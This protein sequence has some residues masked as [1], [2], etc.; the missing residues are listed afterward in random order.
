MSTIFRGIGQNR[1]L[2]CLAS[3]NPLETDVQELA[4]AIANN[5][6]PDALHINM[7]EFAL[8]TNYIKLIR[9]FTLNR[10]IKVLS[11]VG[12]AAPDQL[13]ES[14]CSALS[15]FLSGNSTIRYLDLS[16][17]SSKLEEG[18]LGRGFSRA[19]RGIAQNRTLKHLR[20]RNQNLNINIGDL[21]NALSENNTLVTLDV[22]ENELSLSNF[23]YLANSLRHNTTILELLVFSDKESPMMMLEKSM[24]SVAHLAGLSVPVGRESNLFKASPR[25]EKDRM[26]ETAK[27]L[28]NQ[29]GDE[30][31]MKSTQLAE[32]LARNRF[33]EE[34]R[35]Q[36]ELEDSLYEEMEDYSD[37]SSFSDEF[38]G[39][40]A[41][42]KEVKGARKL[43]MTPEQ[44]SLQTST[45][46]ITRPGVI[47]LQR[48]MTAPHHVTRLEIL[49]SPTEEGTRSPS[50]GLPSPPELV[51]EESPT[52]VITDKEIQ[53]AEYNPETPADNTPHFDQNLVKL[54]RT[55]SEWPLDYERRE[56]T[57]ASY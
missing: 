21:A 56:G 41:V 5:Y 2:S 39:L 18:R 37:S 51:N 15:N 26:P 28:M 34:K 57:R 32:I 8:E 27:T 45:S 22:S 3:G 53:D 50:S 55:P 33:I 6:G 14:A 40:A 47:P 9:S 16:G 24:D 4:F 23:A 49:D 35:G 19:L 44:G 29:L 17:F 36:V 20:I 11:L 52:S 46:T 10:N 7:I 25:P 31:K 42:R 43:S 30:W 1:R 54:M 38:G 48:V 13:S 12:T